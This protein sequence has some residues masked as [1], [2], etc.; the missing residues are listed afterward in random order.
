MSTAV[1]PAFVGLKWG[2]KKTPVWGTQVQTTV[3]KR[4]LRAVF[5]SAPVYKISLSYEVL[6]AAVA[7]AEIQSLVGFYNL[8]S[9]SFDT[10][11]YNDPDDRSATD[12]S[13]GNYATGTTVYYANKFYGSFIEPI[14][15]FNGNPTNV[16]V[17][18]V[19]KTLGVDYTVSG[20]KITFL[21]VQ[22]NGAAITWTGLYYWNVR[23]HDDHMD[24]DQFMKDLWEAK[25]VDFL[26]V[27]S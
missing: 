10:F 13:C 26:S 21:T 14:G 24:F 8:R 27:K 9:G 2:I 16:K 11:Y 17:A 5:M 22:T 15:A 7:Y 4:E 20:N 25:K 6:R 19:T 3:S 23:F 1:F 18:G 12:V